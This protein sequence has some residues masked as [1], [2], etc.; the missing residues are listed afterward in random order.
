MPQE[1]PAHGGATGKN[2][3]MVPSGNPL[4]PFPLRATILEETPTGLLLEVPAPFPLARKRKVRITR[5]DLKAL[6]E[7]ADARALIPSLNAWNRLL[8][9]RYW[10][11]EPMLLGLAWLGL[12][13]AIGTIAFVIAY[14]IF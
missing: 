4:N 8:G 7:Q 5:T 6:M 3:L 2:S 12:M 14:V 9:E 13:L 11:D 10:W 1:T